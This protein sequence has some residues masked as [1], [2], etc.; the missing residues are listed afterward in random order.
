MKPYSGL[1][2]KQHLK[3]GSTLSDDLYRYFYQEGDYPVAKYLREP[4][5]FEVELMQS[6]DPNLELFLENCWATLKEDR[7]SLPSWDII[8]D[9]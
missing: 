3:C 1:L 5:Y 4:L 9:G 8:V 6:T 7:T 2:R